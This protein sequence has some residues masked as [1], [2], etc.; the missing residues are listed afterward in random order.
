MELTTWELVE[1]LATIGGLLGSSLIALKN[2]IGQLVW[3]PSNLLWVI[4]GIHFNKWG[5]TVQCSVF[6]LLAVFGW[7]WWGKEIKYNK[8][9]LI[10]NEEL[11]E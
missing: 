6:L 4:F 11:N 2:R 7:F 9:L 10:I 8:Q 3:I 5:L 1:Y